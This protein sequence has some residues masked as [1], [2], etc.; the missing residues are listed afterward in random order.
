MD[1]W[2]GSH[3]LLAKNLSSDSTATALT[4]RIDTEV[5]S[6]LYARSS[7]MTIRKGRR[8]VKGEGGRTVEKIAEAEKHHS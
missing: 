5:P 4:R 1:R 2:K 7:S 3:V 8:C 6:Q